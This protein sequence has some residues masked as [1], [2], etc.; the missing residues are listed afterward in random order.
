[1]RTAAAGKKQCDA[2][3]GETKPGERLPGL[4]DIAR[5]RLDM[6]IWMFVQRRVAFTYLIEVAGGDVTGARGTKGVEAYGSGR[7]GR[8]ERAAKVLV[9][10]GEERI[11]AREGTKK[12]HRRS[13]D[14]GTFREERGDLA[15]VYGIAPR[16]AACEANPIDNETPEILARH[17]IERRVMMT[18]CERAERRNKTYKVA[19]RAGKNHQH[20]LRISDPLRTS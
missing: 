10:G 4:R 9:V 13:G 18:P 20:A 19:E 15:S 1:M 5:Q 8:F 16:I 12:L 6:C 11:D 14:V 17:Q 7:G 2:R 3:I